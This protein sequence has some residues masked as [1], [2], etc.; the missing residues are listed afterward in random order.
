MDEGDLFPQ[1]A[2][3]WERLSFACGKYAQVFLYLDKQHYTPRQLPKVHSKLKLIVG[4]ILEA[5]G[6]RPT[7]T[8]EA[9]AKL[10]SLPLNEAGIWLAVR[11]MMLECSAKLE[12]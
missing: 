7:L 5:K 9:G 2:L 10:A 6:Y 8:A 4:S 3:K 11:G 12:S 1:L